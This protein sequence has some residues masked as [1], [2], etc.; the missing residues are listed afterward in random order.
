VRF[1]LIRRYAL[2]ARYLGD[3][4]KCRVSQ[5]G[6]FIGGCNL[7]GVWGDVYK[8][9]NRLLLVQVGQQILNPRD[10]AD[11]LNHSDYR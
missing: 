10:Y 6:S 3:S 8:V 5:R 4:L 2:I 7:R 11:Q 1:G 9:F